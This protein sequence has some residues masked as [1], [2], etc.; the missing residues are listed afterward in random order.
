MKTRIGRSMKHEMPDIFVVITLLTNEKEFAHITYHMIQKK[1]NVDHGNGPIHIKN[2][3]GAQKRIFIK[4]LVVKNISKGIVMSPGSNVIHTKELSEQTSMLTTAILNTINA[5]VDP[6]NILSLT[7]PRNG[8]LGYFND[9]EEIA[10][11]IIEGNNILKR[12]RISHVYGGGITR[13]M[14]T[15][16]SSRGKTRNGFGKASFRLH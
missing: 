8:Q 10:N 9:I 7:K 2:T 1:V 4:P 16:A 14:K 6:S 13:K 11:E 5:Y 15:Q 12:G 3:K